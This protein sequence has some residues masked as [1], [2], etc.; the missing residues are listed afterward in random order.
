M[1]GFETAVWAGVFDVGWNGSVRGGGMSG[2]CHG[3]HGFVS[4]RGLRLA[5]A[6]V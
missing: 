3:P 2:G 4:E 1:R 5:I 6:A